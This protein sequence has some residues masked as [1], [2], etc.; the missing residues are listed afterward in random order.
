PPPLF[1]DYL[2][3]AGYTI[4][5]PMK[6]GFGKTD[7]NFDVPPNAFDVR[8][9]WTKSKPKEPF[10]GFFNITWSHESKI[11]ASLEEFAK[12]TEKLKPTERHD[13]AKMNVPPYHPDAP[14]V[15][16]DLANYYDLVTAVDHKVGAVLNLLETQ[17]LASNT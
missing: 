14:E 8:D 5:W 2:K 16:R 15:R 13:P 17:G 10:F 11:R 7:F 4:C 3:K 6:A 12:L 1:T 9:D